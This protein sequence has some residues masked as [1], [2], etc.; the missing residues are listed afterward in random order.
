[1]VA[2]MVGL[3]LAL[4]AASSWSSEAAVAESK[5]FQELNWAVTTR[6]AELDP[7][8]QAELKSRRDPIADHGAPFNPTDVQAGEQLPA[9]RLVLAGHARDR[10]FVC[11]EVGGVAHILYLAMFKVVERSVEVVFVAPGSVGD[12]DAPGGWAVDVSQLK[13]AL[14][15]GRL[16]PSDPDQYLPRIASPPR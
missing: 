9:A 16:R 5:R 7:R 1:M 2:K 12:R 13:E 4:S 11:L 10:W 15:D 6:L 3:S 14:R 8:V